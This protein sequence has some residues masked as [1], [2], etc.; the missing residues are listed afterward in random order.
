MG[1]ASRRWRTSAS[2]CPEPVKCRSHPCTSTDR[3]PLLSRAS[4][5][6]KS[7][8]RSSQTMFAPRTAAKRQA[9]RGMNDVLPDEASLWERVEDAARETFAKYGYRN[10]RVPI[11]EVTPL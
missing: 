1:Q 4:G 6:R 9:V 7:F 5:L 8:S 3:R 11:V 2:A 10:V